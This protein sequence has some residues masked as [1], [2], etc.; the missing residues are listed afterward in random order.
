VTVYGRWTS[1]T[2]MKQNEETSHN[3]FKWGGEEVEGERYGGNVN[4]VQYKP[5]QNCHYESPLYN[6]Y[7]LVQK[8]FKLVSLKTQTYI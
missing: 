7:I 3:C 5:N 8:F 6:E 2:C 1:Y 4:N